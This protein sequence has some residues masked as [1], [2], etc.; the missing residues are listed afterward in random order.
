MN[1]LHQFRTTAAQASGGTSAEAIYVAVLSNALSRVSSGDI[2][3]FGAGTGNLTL[4]FHETRRF[5]FVTGADILPRPPHLPDSIAW[6]QQDLNGS[7]APHSESFDLILSAEVMEHLETPR[8]VPR[9]WCSLLRCRGTLVLS[10]PNNESW[11]SLL[12][13]LF[14]G[15]FIAFT[16]ACYPAHITALVRKDIHRIV[17]EAGLL[18]VTFRFTDCGGIPKWPH[19]T[20]QCVGG[21]LFQGVRYSDNLLAVARKPR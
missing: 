8:A 13:L 9:E 18:D 17:T 3:D 16:D 20:W 14:R 6:I 10:T 4:R 21:R 7:V 5:G 1:A 15:H 12:S 2:L 11:R 19:L